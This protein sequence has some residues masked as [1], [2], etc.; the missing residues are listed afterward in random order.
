MV[1]RFMCLITIFHLLNKYL[2]I[3][4]YNSDL[5]YF[6]KSSFIKKTNILGRFSNFYLLVLF[7]E[8]FY[9]I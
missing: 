1:L 9:I 8:M 3:M 7:Y 4:E 6:T 5:R 2:I